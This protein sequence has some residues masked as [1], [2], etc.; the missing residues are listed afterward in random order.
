MQEGILTWLI[1][2][3]L[4]A[5][6]LIGLVPRTFRQYYS[7]IC[8]M[9]LPLMWY[10]FI[11]VVSS[12]NVS[13]GQY[14]VVE[15]VDWIQLS[16]GKTGML[17]ID[18]TVGLDALSLVM[19]GLTLVVFTVGILISQKIEKH[20]K[21][22]FSLLM[23]MFTS[24]L[25]CFLALDFFL[26]FIFFEFMLLPMYFLIGI[27]GGPNRSY[28]SMKF[29]IYTL[30]GSVFI[31][32][33]MFAL[34]F[35][36]NDEFFSNEYKKLVYS[37]DYRILGDIKNLASNSILS[38]KNPTYIGGMPARAL[39]F[40]LL[41][42]GFGIKLPVVPFHTWLPDAHVEAPTPVSVVL[43]GILL[44]IGG[45]G[46][47]RIVYGFL[48]DITLMHAH[49]LGLLGLIAIIYGGFNAL[50]Q[51]DLKKMIAYSSV[52]HMGFVTMG[53]GA[54]TVEAW[55]GAIFQMFSHGILSAMLFIIVGVLYDRTKNR[56]IKN[57]KGIAEKMPLYSFMA[58]IAF[59]ASMGLPGFS[60]FI[61]EFFSIFGTFKSEYMPKY[62]SILSVLGI[63]ISAVYF[64]WTYQKMFFG[65]FQTSENFENKLFD[66]DLVETATLG[67]LAILTLLFGVFPQL[68]F[69]YIDPLL[70]QILQ[71][72]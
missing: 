30:V 6:G 71:L 54:L 50:A 3:P 60:G 35:S 27:W 68:I 24:V 48:P 7:W 22:Y 55:G 18:Y 37:F 14:Q 34:A 46:L 47:I 53:F 23:L 1:F 31:L 33:A 67:F 44:K 72:K 51:T 41:L 62:I 8:L 64:L 43:A 66:L 65:K 26:F 17:I 12:F 57:F 9:V 4:F 16:L 5:A 19:V 61:G 52:S 25:G 45:Y 11:Q 49:V 38:I 56:E 21:A 28:A 29:L 63:F 40:I 20:E 15:K 36:Y 70:Q 32:V 13:G 42:L 2:L 39:V 58:A 69:K 10:I 59:F